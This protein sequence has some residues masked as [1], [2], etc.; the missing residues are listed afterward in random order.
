MV[1]MD[2]TMG[3]TT[4]VM[5]WTDSGAV[6]LT[7]TA[8]FSCPRC[9]ERLQPNIEHRCGDRVLRSANAKPPSPKRRAGGKA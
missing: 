6:C 8:L 5:D 1:S 4:V 9:G 3:M 7:N 2:W